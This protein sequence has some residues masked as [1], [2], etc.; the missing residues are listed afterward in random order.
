MMEQALILLEQRG[1]ARRPECFK[2]RGMFPHA[3]MKHSANFLIYKTL[4]KTIYIQS[5]SGWKTCHSQSPGIWQALQR[6]HL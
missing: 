5:T 3:G 2:E 6:R 1:I 4:Y